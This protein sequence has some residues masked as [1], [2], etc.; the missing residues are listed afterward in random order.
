MLELSQSY[1]IQVYNLLN[2]IIISEPD[3]CNCLV[4]HILCI[5]RKTSIFKIFSVGLFLENI[6]LFQKF[7]LTYHFG[8]C[9]VVKCVL[10][11]DTVQTETLKVPL[12]HF[13]FTFRFSHFCSTTLSV[14]S[15]RY[16]T[17]AMLH[18]SHSIDLL[19]L[20]WFTNTCTIRT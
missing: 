9:C 18:M 4:V 11:M 1:M 3:Y 13:C 12:K 8:Y 5:A 14:W 16:V 15:V 20:N 7:P 6:L 10:C 19:D 2:T 17:S